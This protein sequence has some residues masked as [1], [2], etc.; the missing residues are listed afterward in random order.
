[1]EDILLSFTTGFGEPNIGRHIHFALEAQFRY[2]D[3]LFDV[4]DA[5]D[6]AGEIIVLLRIG[7]FKLLDTQATHPF[8]CLP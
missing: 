1:M 8:S 3:V 4:L 7:N 5:F 2:P 6:L